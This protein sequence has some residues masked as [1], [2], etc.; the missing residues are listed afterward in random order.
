MLRATLPADITIRTRLEAA[1][2]T[3]PGDAMQIHQVAMNLCTNA[4][5]AM[6]GTG[7]L[8]AGWEAHSRCVSRWTAL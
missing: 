6:D 2:A 8:E 3:V 7:T 1:A 5:H 4:I